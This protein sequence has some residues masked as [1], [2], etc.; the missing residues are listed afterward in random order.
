V[1]LSDGEYADLVRLAVREIKRTQPDLWTKVGPPSELGDAHY[2]TLDGAFA[3]AYQVLAQQLERQGDED[4]AADIREGDPGTPSDIWE[5]ALRHTGYSAKLHGL[6]ELLLPTHTARQ[7][8]E[9]D[10]TSMSLDDAVNELEGWAKKSRAALAGTPTRD[11]LKGV[12]ELWTAP[13]R[14]VQGDW[15]ALV[16]ALVADRALA[17]AVRYVSLRSRHFGDTRGR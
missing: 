14:V 7:L 12:L 11:L 16:G 6:A 9:L 10:F 3:F 15:R 5:S 13:D 4:R 2:A 17:R 1:T 8:I